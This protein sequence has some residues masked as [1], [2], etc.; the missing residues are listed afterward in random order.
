MGRPKGTSMLELGRCPAGHPLAGEASVFRSGG[1]VMCRECARLRQ[2]RRQLG[3]PA[4]HRPTQTE[5]G[6]CAKAGHLWMGPED[7]TEYVY[8]GTPDEPRV[9]RVV[10]CWQ[11]RNGD[12]SA[13][14]PE[15][16]IDSTRR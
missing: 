15:R 12:D 8:G 13:A 16:T 10:V 2:L 7:Y 1:R 3:L 5:L 14:E 4:A 9:R 11:C 6:R